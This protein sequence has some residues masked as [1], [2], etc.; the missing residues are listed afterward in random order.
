MVTAITRTMLCVFAAVALVSVGCVRAAESQTD[1]AR[2]TAASSPCYVLMVTSLD[3]QQISSTPLLD[4]K[5]ETVK[6]L[7]DS[8]YDGIAL[9]IVDMRSG[10]PVPTREDIIK[11]AEE[12]AALSTKDIW[13]RVELSRIIE[14][15]PD[16]NAG[17]YCYEEKW[18]MDDVGALGTS[19]VPQDRATR[20]STAYFKRIKGYDL[21]DEAGALKQR[22]RRP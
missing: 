8:P 22:R 15:S 9:E 5:P 19:G 21:Y 11:R 7:N 6:L 18:T 3:G 20:V 16:I 13:P 14:R 4:I 1:P 2:K 10:Q 12:L 17:A